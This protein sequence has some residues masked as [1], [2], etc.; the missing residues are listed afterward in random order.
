MLQE[1]V[2]GLVANGADLIY[3]FSFIL[4]AEVYLMAKRPDASIRVLDEAARRAEQLE[5]R[6]LEVEILR[7]RGET[8]LLLPDGAA[9]AELCFR[10][11]L[12]VAERQQA[13]AWGLRAV[14][15][16]ARLLA[17]SGRRDEGRTALAPVLARFTE[18]FDTY[19]LREAQRLH[20]NL[21]A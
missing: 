6:M 12:E 17:S 13:R 2:E 19:D 5:H 21:K 10:R 14:T 11:A 3:S 8:M 15:S 18:G 1:S 16:L 20:Q 4:L 9:E 7:L